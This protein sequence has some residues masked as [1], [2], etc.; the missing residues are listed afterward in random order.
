MSGWKEP[1]RLLAFPKKEGKMIPHEI[2]DALL[3][4]DSIVHQ[5]VLIREYQFFIKDMT[6]LGKIRIRIYYDVHRKD[7]PFR[8][9]LSHYA[10]TPS[11]AD[12]YVPSTP[13]AET[14]EAALHTAIYSITQ[15]TQ[16]LVGS[17]KPVTQD[18]LVPNADF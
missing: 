3:S 9:E 16:P 4:E 10:N 11:Q 13:Y 5:S 6:D 2:L 17:G 15:W 1:G 8:F 18:W 12:P 14:E 7:L